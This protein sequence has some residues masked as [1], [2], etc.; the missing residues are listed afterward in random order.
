MSFILYAL[1]VLRALRVSCALSVSHALPA[2]CLECFVYFVCSV[3]F[4]KD[5]L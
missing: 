1:S 2:S 3:R 4:F 5:L